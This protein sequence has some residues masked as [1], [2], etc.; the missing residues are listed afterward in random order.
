VTLGAPLSESFSSFAA[1]RHVKMICDSV[2]VP[3]PLVRG[4]KLRCRKLQHEIYK[5]KV[6]T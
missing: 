6:A 3:A 2:V 1:S 5:V 4:S